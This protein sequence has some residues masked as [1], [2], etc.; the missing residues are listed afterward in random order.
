MAC[1]S[2]IVEC[3]AAT[4]SGSISSTVRSNSRRSRTSSYSV[5][6]KTC[7]RTTVASAGFATSRTVSASCPLRSSS[8]GP[9]AS[10]TVS[11]M[12]SESTHS[13]V[14]PRQGGDGD[15]CRWNRGPQCHAVTVFHAVVEYRRMDGPDLDGQTVL[16][17]GS[18]RGVGREL[19]LATADCGAA[20]AVHYHTSADAAREVADQARERGA[21]AAMTVQADVT[22]PDSVD[23]LFAAIEADLGDVDVRR[24]RRHCQDQ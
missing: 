19:L 16:V 4:A 21:T 23:G 1:N 9:T 3:R 6:V 11:S 18:A 10:N 2:W 22:D 13:T 24:G 5:L 8:P 14:K 20:T 15:R 17:T 7:A 12:G